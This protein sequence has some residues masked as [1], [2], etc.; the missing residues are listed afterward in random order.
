MIKVSVYYPHSDGAAFDL[1]YYGSKHMPMVSGLLGEAC[2]GA[3]W[4]SGIGGGA[5][6]QPPPFVAAAHLLFDSVEDFQTAFA[7][8]AGQILGDI[9]NYTAIAP[10]MQVSEVTTVPAGSAG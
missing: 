8:H 6:G 5:P 9:P 3:S 4:D 1:E 7:P 2:K 10:L